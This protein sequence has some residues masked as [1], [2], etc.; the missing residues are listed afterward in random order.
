MFGIKSI[1]NRKGRQSISCL[2]IKVI[3]IV[4]L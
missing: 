3:M 1:S 2:C 4:S